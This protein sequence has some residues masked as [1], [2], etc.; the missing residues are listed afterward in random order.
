MIITGDGRTLA[1]VKKMR[2]EGKDKFINVYKWVNMCICEG[3]IQ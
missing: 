3:F 1:K 2:E